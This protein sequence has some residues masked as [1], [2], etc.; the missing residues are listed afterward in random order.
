MLA[1]CVSLTSSFALWP[2]LS[3]FQSKSNTNAPGYNFQSTT[4][5][6]LQPQQLSV[7]GIADC[8]PWCHLTNQ[9]RPN[10][11]DSATS[12]LYVLR[13]SDKRPLYDLI[14]DPASRNFK[15]TANS[16]LYTL[17]A[18]DK[19]PLYDLIKDPAN[20]NLKD[21]ANSGYF[22]LK[23]GD[24]RPLYEVL[25]LFKS[26]TSQ[27]KPELKRDGNTN[28]GKQ[29]FHEG[30]HYQPLTEI[31][32][33]RSGD[34]CYGTYCN[35]EGKLVHWDDYN[36]PARNAEKPAP[37]PPPQPSDAGC[38]YYGVWYPAGADIENYAVQGMCH[39]TYCDWTSNIIHWEDACYATVPSIPIPT[40]S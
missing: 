39:G 20:L 24:S 26:D 9:A 31:S 40:G 37:T 38:K 10:S 4:P 15:D 8:R 11:K 19:R 35:H 29:C 27:A 28:T 21:T 18:G 33:G 25:P 17:Q 36:C 1:S 32:N 34:W 13:P 7:Y 22:T 14:N 2:Y 30:R 23:A 3:M 5:P 6:A 16:D 12:D